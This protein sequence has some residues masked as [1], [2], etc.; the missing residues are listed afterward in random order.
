MMA[1]S[2]QS[3]RPGPRR[4]GR[5]ATAALVAV[6]GVGVLSPTAMAAEPVPAT[7]SDL[8]TTTEALSSTLVLRGDKALTVDPATVKVTVGGQ[9]ADVDV[10]PAAQQPRSTMLV[11]D[12]SGSMGATGMGT[13]RTAVREFLD[14]VPKDV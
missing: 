1:R 10:S 2:S 12:T 3:D 5:L 6:A 8:R 11:I 4:L 13:V 7:L 14:A 9:P